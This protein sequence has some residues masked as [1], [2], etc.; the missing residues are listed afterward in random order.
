MMDTPVVAFVC[1]QNACRSQMAQVLAQ[2]LMPGRATFLSAGTSPADRVDA[3]ALEELSSRGVASQLIDSLRP[4]SLAELP[5]RVDWLVTMGCG[6]ACPS[7]PCAHRE[8]WGLADPMG[9]P[10]GGYEACAQDILAHLA[11]LRARMDAERLGERGA[12]ERG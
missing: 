8:D 5:P 1:T 9:G 2:T 10:K 6:V 11:E 7:L 3:G 12:D 4:K